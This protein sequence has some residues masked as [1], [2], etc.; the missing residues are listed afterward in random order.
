MVGVPDTAAM[1]EYLKSQYVHNISVTITS[2][3]VLIFI[4]GQCYW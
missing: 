2:S 4:G 3:G 1:F